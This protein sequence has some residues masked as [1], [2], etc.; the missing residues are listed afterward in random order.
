[1]FFTRCI[2]CTGGFPGYKKKTIYVSIVSLS[3]GNL[4]VVLNIIFI[5]KYEYISAAYTTLIS[6]LFMFVMAWIMAKY[7]L[8]LRV[9]PLWL[10][11][12]PTL[13]MFGF[14]TLTYFLGN[15]SINIMIFIFIK[16][17]LLFLFSI[18]VF[19]KEIRTVLHLSK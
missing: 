9:S 1:M 17:I 18:I 4:N 11:W 10:F 15:L 8:K 19:N 14:I 16:I 2:L 3:A 5:P 7:I 13:I 6:Y 12:K